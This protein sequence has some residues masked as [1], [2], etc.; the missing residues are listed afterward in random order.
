MKKTQAVSAGIAFVLAITFSLH[1]QTT[2]VSIQ[3]LRSASAG[4]LE[5]M[6]QAVEATTP[7][8]AE[9]VPQSGTFW[10]AQ[11]IN[12]PRSHR[13]L[14]ICR[15]GFWRWQLASGGS[16]FRLRGLE[17]QM[18]AMRML[19]RAMGLEMDNQEVADNSYTIDPTDCGWRSRASATARLGSTCTTQPTRSMPSGIQR[20]CWQIGMCHGSMADEFNGDALLSAD[21]GAA[22]FVFAGGGLDGR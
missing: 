9:S 1:A 2:T 19:S 13:T 5:V 17:Q 20:I 4:N 22:E 6:L 21:A 18:A 7:L 12:D 11:N 10:S 15:R 16:R 14:I 3:S 8:P